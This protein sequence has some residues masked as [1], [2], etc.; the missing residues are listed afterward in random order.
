MMDTNVDTLNSTHNQKN[1]VSGLLEILND[2]LI[3][4]KISILNSEPTYF[5]SNTPKSCIDHIFSNCNDKIDIV[6]TIKHPKID[7]AILVTKYHTSAQIKNP[8]HLFLR[9]YRAIS[10]C[11]ISNAIRNSPILSSIFTYTDPN[12]IAKAFNLEMNS[13]IEFLAPLKK[14]QFKVDYVPYHTDEIRSDLKIQGELLNT[15][16][17]TNNI[18]DWRFLKSL[19]TE[20]DKRIKMKKRN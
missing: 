13:I 11:K 15:A 5:L 4:N 6:Q 7:H 12:L 8:D 17:L 9:N 14:V 19:R 20:L 10:K 16:I 3:K 18:D 1:K 2:F